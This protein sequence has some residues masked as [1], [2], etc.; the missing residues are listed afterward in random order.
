MSKL[1]AQLGKAVADD[2]GIEYSS[3]KLTLQEVSVDPEPIES[4]I[5]AFVHGDDFCYD[6]VPV[7]R[8]I[9]G[10]RIKIPRFHSHPI[11][12]ERL[13]SQHYQRYFV[14]R[15]G[16]LHPL[17]VVKPVDLKNRLPFKIDN[18]PTYRTSIVSPELAMGLR[19]KSLLYHRQRVAYER[20]TNLN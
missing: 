3:E 9:N 20:P 14:V 5:C 13:K 18:D 7:W 2:L 16:T 6:Q 15:S 12:E 17:K 8:C 1:K 19:K 11:I 4:L 10:M